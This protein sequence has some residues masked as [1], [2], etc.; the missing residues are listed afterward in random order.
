[1][2]MNKKIVDELFQ[3]LTQKQACEAMRKGALKLDYYTNYPFLER[4]F[5]YESKLLPDLPT[6]WYLI[7]SFDEFEILVIMYEELYNTDETP[8]LT[9]EYKGWGTYGIAFDDEFCALKIYKLDDYV[10]E[11]LQMREKMSDLFAKLSD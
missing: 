9:Q 8:H 4:N 3:E 5:Y 1:M 10:H 6:E 11:I 2:I 7:R